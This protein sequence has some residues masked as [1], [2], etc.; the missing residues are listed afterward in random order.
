MEESK[1]YRYHKNYDLM[2]LIGYG[3]AKFDK[4]FVKQFGFN[5]KTEFYNY[6]VRIGI[7]GT[8]GAIKNRQD[9]LD[10]FFNNGRKGWYQ[11]SSQY[12]SRKLYMD[13]LFVNEDVVS[14]GNIVKNIINQD[15]KIAFNELQQISPVLK[16]RY[17]SMQETGTEAELY[18]YT[19]YSSEL[20]FK[21]AIIE[22]AR[23]WG[24]GYD[25]QLQI[26]ENYLLVEVKGVKE[27][28]GNLRFTEKEV[29]KA[30]EYEK[31]YFLVVVSNLIESPKMSI[32]ENPLSTFELQREE[33]PKIEINYYSKSLLW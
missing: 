22:D 13:S 2:N 20:I 4:E 1:D 28:K 32:F 10:P 23:Q 9:M 30:K 21:N 19:N 17:R 11:K 15:F 27:K 5:T 8:T 29:L 33:K 16:S 14:L 24:D 18:F 31:N 7:C 3:L 26:D 6:V 25:F 12:I